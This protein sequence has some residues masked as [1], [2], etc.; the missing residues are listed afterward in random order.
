MINDNG[1]LVFK[2]EWY[3][4]AVA[5]FAVISLASI[6]IWLICYSFFFDTGTDIVG[7]RICSLGLPIF[8]P[9]FL[10]TRIYLGDIHVDDDGIGWWAWGRRWRYIRWADLKVI[11]ADIVAAYNQIPTTATSYCLYTTAKMSWYNSQRYGMRFDD[12]IPNAEALIQAVDRYVRQHNILVLDRRND[13]AKNQPYFLW[14]PVSKTEV[15]RSSLMDDRP[16]H[17]T[18]KN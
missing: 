4:L 10:V 6:S 11:T 7:D 14:V 18:N 15:R 5:N 1:P 3:V 13:S 12:H 17:D 2:H 8:S 9:L 16:G